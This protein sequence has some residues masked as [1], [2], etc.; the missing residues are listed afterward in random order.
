VVPRTIEVLEKRLRETGVRHP[1]VERQGATRILVRAPYKD[2]AGL[3]PF[4]AAQGRLTFQLADS[5]AGLNAALLQRA[6]PIG[7]ELLPVMSGGGPPAMLVKRQVYLTGDQVKDAGWGSPGGKVT[8]N[9]RL[10][11]A[12]RAAFAKLTREHIGGIVA[13]VLDGK[14]LTAPTIQE[15]IEGGS[16]QIDGN[17]TIE[18]ANALAALLRAGALPAPLTVLDART[19]TAN[20]GANTS[21]AQWLFTGAVLA[22]FGVPLLAIFVAFHVLVWRPH[23]E[24]ALQNGRKPA[25]S[26]IEAVIACVRR[27]FQFSGRA[28]RSEYWWFTLGNIA[29][30]LIAL[31]IDCGL[32]PADPRPY[33]MGAAYWTLTLVLLIPSLAVAVRRLHD[34]NHNGWWLLF[35]LIPLIGALVVIVQQV[36]R[37]TPGDNRYGPDPLA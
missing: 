36:R 2:A 21:A 23:R 11:D 29:L 34:T 24:R 8:I 6:V 26:Q 5:E 14:V 30:I 9:F 32:N 37:G 18:S 13:I 17:F 3:T 16:G 27:T 22:L 7:D 25:L 1:S 35:S 28:R 12:G 20:E 19:V 33:V 4:L 31:V 15:P 10:D